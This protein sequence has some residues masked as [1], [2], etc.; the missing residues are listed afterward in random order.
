MTKISGDTP[1]LR[2][3]TSPWS[4]PCLWLLTFPYLHIG[5]L[6]IWCQGVDL[7]KMDF[8]NPV[9]GPAR[10]MEK[11]YCWGISHIMPVDCSA[12]LK[13]WYALQYSCVLGIFQSVKTSTCFIKSWNRVAPLGSCLWARILSLI[14]LNHCHQKWSPGLELK[15]LL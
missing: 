1:L 8:D 11:C 4:P 3:L 14:S 6:E 13:A 10:M 15:V 7:K 9:T 12:N 2:L 5:S